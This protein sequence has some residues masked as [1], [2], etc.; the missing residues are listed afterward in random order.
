MGDTKWARN[1]PEVGFGE[2]ETP[3]ARAFF[4]LL[5]FRQAE[6]RL[7]SPPHQNLPRASLNCIHRPHE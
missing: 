5:K 2:R 4:P 7:A 1:S 3:K 6:G